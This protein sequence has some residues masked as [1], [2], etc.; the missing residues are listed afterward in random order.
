MKEEKK[1]CYRYPHPAVTT[2]CVLFALDG[3]DTLRVLL[4]ERGREPYRGYWAFPGGF[5]E[6]DESAE[7]GALRELREETGLHSAFIREFGTFSDPGRDPRERVISIAFFALTR[8]RA[9]KGMDDASDARWW[10][11]HELPPLAFDHGEMFRRAVEALR[12][13]IVLDGARLVREGERFT[14]EEMKTILSLLPATVCA[15][16]PSNHKDES[17]TA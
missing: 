2:D 5:L 14:A 1:Y 15:P 17:P 3:D 7:Q 13:A 16:L 11:I 12:R 9:V 10:S 6:M 8:M 4:V